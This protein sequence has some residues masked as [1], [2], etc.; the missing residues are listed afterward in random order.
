[1]QDTHPTSAPRRIPTWVKVTFT[2]FMAVL[3]PS[4]WVN[5]G[6][7]NF[8]FFCDVALF[9]TLLGVWLESPRLLGM[10][11]VGILFPQALWVADFVGNLVGLRLS[12]MTDY[13]FDS[14]NPLPNRALSLFHGW[15]PFLLAWLVWRVG[16]DRRAFAAW[17]ATA[18]VLIAVCYL[19]MPAPPPDPLQP[20][21][22]VNINYVYGFDAQQKQAWMPDL[23]WVGVWL[24][25]Q[26]LVLVGP[27][28]L[29]LR[30]IAP[31]PAA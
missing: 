18:W 3:V 11:A 25:A 17:V 7:T 16:Y 12:G 14:G 23:A 19:W 13:M 6:P 31:R 2:A 4:Y 22:P 15:L 20:N 21:V 5:Y 24:L 30:R 10:A 8:L 28:H 9:L 26:P 29:V 27:T 1:M